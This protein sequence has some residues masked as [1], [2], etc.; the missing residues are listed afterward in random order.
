LNGNLAAVVTDEREII[1]AFSYDYLTNQLAPGHTLARPALG[2]HYLDLSQIK[3][4]ALTQTKGA[5]LYS[6]ASDL[7]VT[8]G[9]AAA[10]AGLKA[11]DV[12]TWVNNQKIDAANDLGDLLAAYQAGDKITL[13]YERDGAEQEVE[14]ILGALKQ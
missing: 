13:T 14:V 12:I 8:K 6:T 4:P 3:N 7:A 9:S 5:W 1:P 11:G 10:I 2:V